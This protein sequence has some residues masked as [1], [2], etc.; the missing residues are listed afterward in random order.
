MTNATYLR[1]K[2]GNITEAIF[3]GGTPDTRKPEYW[4]GNL[5]WLSSGETSQPYITRTKKM[6]TQEGAKNSST[7]LAKKGDVVIASAGQGNTRGQTSFLKNDMYI[8]QSIIS[9]RANPNLLDSLYLYYNIS[10]RN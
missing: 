5:M 10:T 9:L 6:I 4:N 3:S 8:N 1:K 2:I 7:R